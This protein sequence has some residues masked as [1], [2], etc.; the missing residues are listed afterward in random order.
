VFLG[1]EYI[2]ENG[3]RQYVDQRSTTHND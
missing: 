1:Y 2:D 3:E